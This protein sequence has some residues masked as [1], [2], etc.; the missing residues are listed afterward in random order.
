MLAMVG[1]FSIIFWSAV[2]FGFLNFFNLLRVSS[3]DEF[4]GM[5]LLKH[6]ESAYPAAVSYQT[7]CNGQL[8]MMLQAWVVG[9]IPV[10]NA[11]KHGADHV[12]AHMGYNGPWEPQ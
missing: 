7:K 8:T 2:V 5:D 9:I 12:P 1:D 10:C 4:K 6:G 3:E 11:Y